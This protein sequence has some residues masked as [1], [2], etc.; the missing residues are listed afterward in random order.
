M[1]S[2]IKFKAA[3]LRQLDEAKKD[4]QIG[5]IVF[6]TET[7]QFFMIDGNGDYVHISEETA[8]MM[9]ETADAVG[10][11]NGEISMS[12]YEINQQIISQLPTHNEEEL[13]K[14]I[15]IINKFEKSQNTKYYM[16]LCKEIS[17]FTGFIKEITSVETLGE[18]VIDCI[19]AVGEIKTIDNNDPVYLDIWVTTKQ[20]E[21]HC[22]HLFDY[23]YGVVEFGG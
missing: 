5:D 10:Q 4:L 13:K 17:Y 12:L 20:G 7:E 6:L 1:D 8:K 19:K 15:E 16:L 18:V 9:K 3:S 23:Q 2:L 14:D 11:M 21:T 22:M